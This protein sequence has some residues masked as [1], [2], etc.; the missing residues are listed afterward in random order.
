MKIYTN[1]INESWIIDRV[2]S[3]WNENNKDISTKK[4]KESDIVWIISNWTWEKIPKKY[5]KKNKVVA[6]IYHIDFD[7]FDKKEEQ[8]FKKMDQYVDFY[9]VISKKTKEQL[10]QLTN[11]EVFSIPFWINQENLFY[12]EEKLALRKKYGY[13]ENEFIVGSFQRDTEGNDLVSPKLIKGP[14]IFLEVVKNL[15]KSKNL[16]VLLAG[17]RRQ[18][19]IRNLEKLGISYKYYEMVNINTLNEFYNIL[20]LYIVSS[21]IEGG[22]QAIIECATTKTP[23]ISTDVGVA[24]E[25]LHSDSIYTLENFENAK[26]MV[27]YAYKKSIEFKIPKGMEKFREMFKYLYES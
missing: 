21:R 7:K 20:D 25:I 9:H 1:Q 27:E 26:P 8:N 12:I 4:I 6:S 10:E 14:D 11:K 19:I 3:E 23:I 22:P 2:I 15:N 5:L 18:Y 17:T 24:S 16:K 13:L